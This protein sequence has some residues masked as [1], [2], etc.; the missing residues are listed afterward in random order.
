MSTTSQLPSTASPSAA[1]ITRPSFETSLED[2]SVGH[3]DDD[4]YF[5]DDDFDEQGQTYYKTLC[6]SFG[7]NFVQLGLNEADTFQ[8]VETNLS[9]IRIFPTDI[10]FITAGWDYPTGFCRC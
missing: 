4:V 9:N 7:S 1:F 6:L 2:D 3:D 10:C 8:W 5:D